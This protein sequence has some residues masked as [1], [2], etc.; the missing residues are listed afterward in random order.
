MNMA[1]TFALGLWLSFSGST[2]AKEAMSCRQISALTN[3]LK[4]D[5]AL[6]RDEEL[7]AKLLT[8]QAFAESLRDGFVDQLDPAKLLWLAEDVQRA[9]K[10]LDGDVAA[11]VFKNA[12]CGAFANVY[13]AYRSAIERSLRL[14]PARVGAEDP[15]KNEII[16]RAEK[17]EGEGSRPKEWAQS[18]NELT[19]RM[20]TLLVVGTRAMAKANGDKSYA[21]AYDLTRQSIDRLR[22]KPHLEDEVP[23]LMT[24][25]ILA[26]L[27]PHTFFF[28]NE[29]YEE[30]ASSLREFAGLG[31]EIRPAIDGVYIHAVMPNGPAARSGLLKDG[32]KIVK[33]DDKS[34]VDLDIGQVSKLLR[35]AADTH[36]KIE[37]VRPSEPKPVQIDV[38]RGRVSPQETT[39]REVIDTPTGPVGYLRFASFGFDGAKAVESIIHELEQ[40]NIRGL[41][42]DLRGNPGGLLGE[43][44]GI[45][46]LVERRAPARALYYL[47]TERP[48]PIAYA[49][50]KDGPK[51]DLPLIVLID[52]G[53]ASASEI[54]SG[55][56]QAYGRALIIGDGPTFGKGSVQ[57]VFPLE[58]YAHNHADFAVNQALGRAPKGGMILTSGFYFLPDGTSIQNV[59][60]TPDVVLYPER[61]A[62]A[63][64]SEKGMYEHSLP[65]PSDLGDRLIAQ[66][67]VDLLKPYRERMAPARQALI[68]AFA[69]KKEELRK[70][71]PQDPEKAAAVF[72]LEEL[73]KHQ[74]G[75]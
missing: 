33:V 4:R 57:Q 37:V 55:A 56:L 69:E 34:L 54:V 46:N 74:P 51:F 13:A 40:K 23:R 67:D 48:E 75:T 50:K 26:N 11:L 21:E 49:F 8:D 28:S 61:A 1:L 32:D 60:V 63:E 12:D 24:S 18:E 25:V 5:H 45:I 59:G 2:Q 64:L 52:A 19:E 53:S 35:G 31:V 44:V 6:I 17:S 29:E 10:S 70:V 41:I 62:G 20:K 66:E 27:D 15:I 73:I 39:R 71:N 36:V 7:K 43:A 38:V 47:G 22:V 58:A 14:L 9:K 42:L 3:L 68:K 30:Y 72:L 16:A 65:R